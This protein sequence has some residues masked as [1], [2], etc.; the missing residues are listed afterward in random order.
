MPALVFLCV[1]YL[2]PTPAVGRYLAA[3]GNV[4]YASYLL[5]VPVQITVCI[6]YAA[7]GQSVPWRQPV[8][9]MV[10]LTG[11]L[12]L[13]HACYRGFEMPMQDLLRKALLRP[14]VGASA[15]IQARPSEASGD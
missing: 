13:S 12:L 4:T 3:A 8:M 9:F 7:L 10:F 6:I 14:R 1:R 15:S 11:I 2:R 5:H